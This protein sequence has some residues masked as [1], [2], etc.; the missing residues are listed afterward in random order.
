MNKPVSWLAH[1]QVALL[2]RLGVYPT[3]VFIPVYYQTRSGSTVHGATLDTH[4]HCLSINE[5]FIDYVNKEIEFTY[6][7]FLKPIKENSLYRRAQKGKY[8]T[9]CFMQFSSGNFKTFK[10]EDQYDDVFSF[11]AE[12]FPGMV[13]IHRNNIL[14]KYVSAQRGIIHQLWHE[15]SSIQD[16]RK[17]VGVYLDVNN[18]N[19]K[20]I[21][22]VD[23]LTNLINWNQKVLLSA[24]QHIPNL[25][26][27]VYEEDI[28]TDVMIGV[29]KVLDFFNVPASAKP[30]YIPLAKTSR[31]LQ[32]DIENYNEVYA[33]LKDS[34]HAWMLD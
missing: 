15:S 29:Q 18:V 5:A 19:G 21:N 17:N 16:S 25:L 1:K 7:D 22:L 3:P 31:G 28:E 4:T 12:N 27:L 9:H 13:F 26:E 20:N 33:F 34:P 23:H 8:L 11:V 14:K 10:K 24:Q 30:L 6:N 2:K 32:Y